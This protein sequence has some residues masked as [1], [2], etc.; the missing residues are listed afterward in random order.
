MSISE[1]YR[2]EM[3]CKLSDRGLFK[4][5]GSGKGNPRG[6]KC[7]ADSTN[8]KKASVTSYLFF[9]GIGQT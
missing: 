4:L 9:E 1:G 2:E 7:K 5:E 3:L 6:I 8:D